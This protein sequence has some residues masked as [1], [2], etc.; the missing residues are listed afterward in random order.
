MEF[1]LYRTLNLNLV[2]S[3]DLTNY[4]YTKPILKLFSIHSGN[5]SLP[6]L[7]LFASAYHWFRLPLVPNTFHESN[8]VCIV[9]C[10]AKIIKCN[11]KLIQTV[12]WLVILID[13]KLKAN[14][15]YFLIL[16]TQSKSNNKWSWVVSK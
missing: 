16:K 5:V 8:M 13:N 9:I 3:M 12:T 15:K 6:G 2:N 4:C 7:Y 14:F 10:V 1:F 11:N